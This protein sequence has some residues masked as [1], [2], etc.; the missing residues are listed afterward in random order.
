MNN[1]QYFPA[2]FQ[3]ALTGKAHARGWLKTQLE[4]QRDGLST[5]LAESWPDI[6]QSKWIGGQAEGWERGP[7]WLDGAVA[8]AFALDDE[9]LKERVRFWIDAILERQ[10]EDGWLGAK[11]DPHN[12][13]GESEL[14]PWPLALVFKAFAQWFEATG[15]ERIL[16]S[17]S[18]ALKRIDTLLDE[19]PLHNWAK[20]RW[21]EIAMG[22]LWMYEHTPEAW[23]LELAEKMAAQGYDW[24]A[25]FDSF[26]KDFGARSDSWTLENHVVNNAMAIKEAAVR[27][28]F[29][30]APKGPNAKVREWLA[31]HQLNKYHGQANGV[32]SGD[33]SLA[34]LS[35]SQG[36][37]LCAVVEYLYSLQVLA[38]QFED[39]FGLGDK[40]ERIAFNALP[41]TFTSDMW[42]HQYDQQVNQ[43]LVSHA[44]RDWVSNGDEANIFGLEPNFGCCTAN[45]HQGW[46]KLVQSLVLRERETGNLV[47]NAY[48]PCSVE[49]EGVKVTIDTAYPFRDSIEITM[50]LA[51]PREFEVRLR[52]PDWAED[53]EIKINGERLQVLAERLFANLKREWKSGD[54]IS[55]RFPMTLRSEERPNGARSIYYGPLLMGLKIEEEF[56]HLKGEA[57]ACY[58]EVHPA[59]PWNY[60][61]SPGFEGWQVVQRPFGERPFSPEGV[62]LQV[63]AR[64]RR[65]ESWTMHNS[66]A[67]PPPPSP[68]TCESEEEEVTLLPY[69]ATHLRVAEFPVCEG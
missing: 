37:E 53:F 62:P 19:K 23:L 29:E 56:K 39:S 54:R 2:R 33:E 60:A 64:A 8:L 44:K 5:Y 50:E 21:F 27:T 34:G 20:M 40:L 43:V 22:P 45:M 26:G 49:F 52:V 59:S 41:A 51:E 18:R 16:P 1:H 7:Y 17:M 13:S 15:D 4:L 69:G 47:V 32:F 30:G 11:E 12:G 38:Q 67:A 36:T 24:A 65:L 14:D 42:A 57:P 68:V 31:M 9:P 63:L 10:H 3:T 61:L 6:A 35:P 48:M 25:H 66:S 55:L 28:R 58:W 46:P